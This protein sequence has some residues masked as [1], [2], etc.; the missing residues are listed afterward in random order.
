VSAPGCGDSILTSPPEQCDDG[1]TTAG[2]GCDAMCLAEAPWEIEPN[3]TT[4]TATALWPM[5]S[6][7]RGK[8]DPVADRDYF[9][10]QLAAGQKPVLATHSV[11]A[12]NACTFDTVIH[13][14]DANGV[15]I[16][17]DDDDG[18]NSCSL[19]SSTNDPALSNLPA[20]TY[21]VWVQDYSDN[22]AIGS[23]ELSLT[24]Q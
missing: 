11:G 20:G 19:L 21:Y 4:A 6:S 15:Q 7:W 14:L 23:Y 3:G 17:E 9:T 22:D 5:T 10:F 24:L 12:P 2:D 8:I 16:A 1:N 18:T 13:L